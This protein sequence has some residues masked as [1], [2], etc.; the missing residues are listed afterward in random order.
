MKSLLAA[1]VISPYAGRVPF[2]TCLAYGSPSVSS[3]GPR[4]K[5]RRERTPR[6]PSSKSRRELV[7]C[8]RQ[9]HL[10]PILGEFVLDDFDGTALMPLLLAG[11]VDNNP[12][13][14]LRPPV[15]WVIIWQAGPRPR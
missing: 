2:I 4:Y 13:G 15:G 11:P 9:Q 3:N 10:P 8:H 14:T 12:R 1:V 5:S 6:T 7:W